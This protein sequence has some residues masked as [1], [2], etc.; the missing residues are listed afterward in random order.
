[1]NT[2]SFFYQTKHEKSLY[3]KDF[4]NDKIINY[5]DASNGTVCPKDNFKFCFK[6]HD[7]IL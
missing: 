1:M 7:L 6:S 3:L 2:D 5:V 4:E